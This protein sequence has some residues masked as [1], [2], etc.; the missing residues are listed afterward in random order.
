MANGFFLGGA[1]EGMLESRKQ[2]LAE[3]TNE[4]DVGLRRR[5]LDINEKQFAAEQGRKDITRLDE[6]IAS[7]MTQVS[8]VIKAGLE[9]GKPPAQIQQA[10]QPL[11]ASA[12]MLAQRAG[13]DPNAIDAQ[14]TAQLF[15][16]NPVDRAAV[17]GTAAATAAVAQDAAEKKLLQAAAQ[18]G[19]S[20]EPE[21][22]RRYKTSKEKTDAENA[23]RDDFTNQ[24]KQFLTVRDYY[25]NYK[26]AENTG[27]GD[28]TRV[29]AFMKIMDPGSVVMPGEQANAN[30]AAGVPESVRGMYN[31]LVGGGTLGETARAQLAA[32]VERLYAARA[33]QHDRLQTQFST[34][35]KKQGLNP[36]NVT[37]DFSLPPP[38]AP[39]SPAETI[40]NRFP[41]LPAP[42]PGFVVQ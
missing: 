15:Q 41:N 38:A 5:A 9:G 21:L 16:P 25:T 20:A 30:N 18:P 33:A 26:Q 36:N 28:I 19:G 42:P 17:T 34:I 31:R 2:S 40:Q 11:L 22:T 3:L 32:Q 29:F 7:T 14:A 37:V 39:P 6:H 35:A 4:Q 8:D 13:R 24:S 27:A 23:L 1:A 10:I 12:K